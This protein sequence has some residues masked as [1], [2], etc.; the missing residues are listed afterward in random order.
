MLILFKIA[1]TG[2][3][4]FLLHGTLITVF[5]N[6]ML[7]RDPK[8]NLSRMSSDRNRSARNKPDVQFIL[9]FPPKLICPPHPKYRGIESVDEQKYQQYDVLYNE[10][11]S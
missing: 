6:N 5:Q 9:E 7:S 1:K 4:N 3:V 2:K 10:I 8:I 11:I